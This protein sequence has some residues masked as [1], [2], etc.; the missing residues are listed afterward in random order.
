[1]VPEY[2]SRVVLLLRDNN[3]VWPTSP[4]DVS[5]FKL[6]H[7]VNMGEFRG[8]VQLLEEAFRKAC[9][10]FHVAVHVNLQSFCNADATG[11]FS[12]KFFGLC[13]SPLEFIDAAQNAVH[14]MS[15]SLALPNELLEAVDM[16][17]K[18]G[19][20]EIARLR[21]ALLPSGRNGP[22]SW[23]RKKSSPRA[24]WIRTCGMHC[25]ANVCCS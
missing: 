22:F 19:H 23:T 13:W 10:A 25:V 8:D 24:T 21:S 9:Q 16:H 14:P 12:C 2:K 3:C 7:S 1:M 6:L 5:S 20:D 15:Y 4:P 11:M 18:H 17:V